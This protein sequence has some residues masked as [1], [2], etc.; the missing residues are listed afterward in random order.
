MYASENKYRLGEYV[1]AEHG[2]VP[3]SWMAHIALGTQRMGECFVFGDILLMG[4]CVHEE[5]GYLALEF[6]E[7]LA[8][9]PVWSKTRYYCLASHIR[10]VRTGRR[11]S[12]FSEGLRARLGRAKKG[13]SDSSGQGAFRLDRYRIAAGSDHAVS[14]E[15]AEGL[16]KVAGGR[17]FVES[18]I[19]FIGPKEFERDA[20]RGGKEWL[21]G[22]KPLP[23]WDETFAW[24]HGGLLRSCGEVEKPKRSY[25]NVFRAGG[26]KARVAS[27]VSFPK[28]SPSERFETS[29]PGGFRRPK[30][31]WSRLAGWK[32][33]WDRSVAALGAGFLAGRRATGSFMSQLAR[34]SRWTRG[35]LRKRNTQ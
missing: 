11:L 29:S 23:P 28:A 33:G 24:G 19:L 31:S 25:W 22:L 17:C 7:E 14:W 32:G 18:G 30:I 13:S 2:G 12:S 4:D 15:A 8:K 20:E 35:W 16:N 10:E 5:A 27:N 6:H 21:D 9:L 26:F 1:I 34:C 3:T